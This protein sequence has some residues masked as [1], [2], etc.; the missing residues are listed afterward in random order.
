MM[1]GGGIAQR[2]AADARGNVSAE[3]GGFAKAAEFPSFGGTDF[4]AR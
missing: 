4:P 2:A 1:S 3:A